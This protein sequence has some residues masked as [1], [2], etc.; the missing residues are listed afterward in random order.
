M[1]RNFQ[2]SSYKKYTESRNYNGTEPFQAYE[3]RY[4]RDFLLNN[5]S[6]NNQT[7]LIDL[8]GWL[9]E[10][11]GDNGLG[12]FYRKQFGMTK[13][14]STYG[15]GYLINWARMSLGNSN[16]TARSVIVELPKV[17]SHEEL[18]SEKYAEKYID[19]TIKM[20]KS[21]V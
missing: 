16:K 8:H 5:K 7:I 20:L 21:I 15:Q 12:E 18:V 1:N 14:I 10:S 3:A 17:N 19:A 9:N 6:K 4:L 13:H 2:T 11:I